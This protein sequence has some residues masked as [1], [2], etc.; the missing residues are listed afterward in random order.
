ML[1]FAEMIVLNN[2]YN[3]KKN[4]NISVEY[5]F[6]FIREV[7]LCKFRSWKFYI[8]IGNFMITY[9]HTKYI[10]MYQRIRQ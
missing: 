2:V 4:S 10:H 8:F 1:S 3:K 7:K 6:N 5:G 9:I